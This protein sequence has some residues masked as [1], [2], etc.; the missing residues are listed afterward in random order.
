M[1]VSTVTFTVSGDYTAA[2]GSSLTHLTLEVPGVSS[3]E[4]GSGTINGVSYELT[5]GGYWVVS[6]PSASPSAGAGT[7]N[8]PFSKAFEGVTGFT[9]AGTTTVHGRTLY[10]LKATGVPSIDASAFG[11]TDPSVSGFTASFVFLAEADGAFAGFDMKATWTQSVNGESV[12]ASMDLRWNVVQSGPSVRVVAPADVW[13]S[14]SSSTLG[15]R[16]LYPASWDVSFV[17]AETGTMEGDQFLGPEDGE[18]H[19]YHYADVPADVTPNAW[20]RESAQLIEK[21]LGGTPEVLTNTTVGELTVRIFTLHGSDEYGPYYFQEAAVFGEGEAWDLDW[22]SNPGTE[23]ADE[24]LF[25]K[26]VQSFSGA[27]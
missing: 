19:V 9:L 6:S 23:S 13:T 8:S 22:F 26:V 15:Y 14:H 20:F 3:I 16:L 17:P 10:L 24:T 5:D 7:S 2:G 18:I 27:P 11:V 1:T 21:N 25:L 4:Q 12:P